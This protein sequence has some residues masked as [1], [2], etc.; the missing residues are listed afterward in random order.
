LDRAKDVIMRGGA[1]IFSV[2]VEQVLTSDPA[3]AEAAV[4]GAADNLGEEAVMATIVLRP[5]ANLDVMALRTLIDT[6]IGRH[7]VPRRI[8][9]ADSLPRNATGKIDK[10]LL[11]DRAN[12]SAPHV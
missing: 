6:T 8:T 3:V 9:T 1:N 7:A 10:V 2:E 4:Y 5:G 11:R 12:E